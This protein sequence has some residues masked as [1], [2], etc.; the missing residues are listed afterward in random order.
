MLDD[1]TNST[2]QKVISEKESVDLNSRLDKIEKKINKIGTGGRSFDIDG[3]FDIKIADPH[4]VF[5]GLTYGQWAGVWMNQLFSDKPDIN[6]EGGKAMVFL[7]GNVQYA[8]L[9]DPEHAVFSTLTKESRLRIFED[10]A[11]FVPVINTKF[12]ID[13]EYQGQV[14][15]DEIAMRNTARRDT[16]NGGQLGIRIRKLDDDKD[17]PLVPDLN[18]FYTESPLFSLSIPETSTYKSQMES[19]LDAGEYFSVTVGIFVI[20]SKWP[21]GTF[22]LSV[23]GKGVGKYLTKSIYDLEVIKG[24]S[25]LVD[26]SNKD[27]SSILAEQKFDPMDFV[28][29]WGDVKAVKET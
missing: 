25:K 27:K 13:L 21:K 16:V 29:N 14:M 5:R 12:V 20:I 26:I 10:T 24:E 2:N 22:R 3:P 28:G 19:P 17:E 4:Y 15:K 1:R 8:Y 6:Y 23:L 9:E 11:V 7:R 18:S